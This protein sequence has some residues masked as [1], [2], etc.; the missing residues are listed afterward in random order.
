[1]R[2]KRTGVPWA[3]RYLS[4]EGGSLSIREREDANDTP[5]VV[6]SLAGSIVRPLASEVNGFVLVVKGEAPTQISCSSEQEKAAW[7]KAIKSAAASASAKSP[8]PLSRRPPPGSSP[9]PKMKEPLRE[10]IQRQ[11]AESVGKL[12]NSGA[13]PDAVLSDGSPPLCAAVAQ[14]RNGLDIAVILLDAG[15]NVRGRDV[16]GATALMKAARLG[17]ADM[18]EMLLEHAG[19]DGQSLVSEVI[20]LLDHKHQSALS[21]CSKHGHAACAELLLDHGASVDL[22]VAD[23]N[24]ALL[25]AATEG[26]D[27]IVRMLLNAGASTKVTDVE[28]ETALMKAAAEGHDPVVHALLDHDPGLIR[29]HNREHF[30]ALHY[31]ASVGHKSVVNALLG[32]GADPRAADTE[33]RTALVLAA[34]FGHAAVAT[35]LLGSLGGADMKTPVTKEEERLGLAAAQHEGH[36]DVV[37]VLEKAIEDRR[38]RDGPGLAAELQKA[39]PEAAAETL[40]A[41]EHLSKKLE[42]SVGAMASATDAMESRVSHLEVLLDKVEKTSGVQKRSDQSERAAIR[43]SVQT[44]EERVDRLEKLVDEQS[45]KGL[46]ARLAR[47]EQKLSDLTVRLTVSHKRGGGMHEDELAEKFEWLRAQQEQMLLVMSEAIQQQVLKP[48]PKD[49]RAATTQRQRKARQMQKVMP[50]AVQRKK[51]AAAATAI[52]SVHRGRKARAQQKRDRAAA[53]AI[54]KHYRTY[55]QRE[56]FQNRLTVEEDWA[57]RQIQGAWRTRQQRLFFANRESVERGYAAAAIQKTVRGK[58][59]AKANAKATVGGRR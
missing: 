32:N 31:A 52:Q 58:G 9:R 38:A 14:A 13:S 51:E 1:M 50:P 2:V 53:A 47:V 26:H 17:N 49:V 8:A 28:E 41:H 24:T 40:Q 16:H 59:K 33:G 3:R 46:E 10:A 37:R 54:Q 55:R 36:D 35:L 22:V 18:V 42:A 25:L 45:E 6:A 5:A 29:H 44:L 34:M 20:D 39:M 30:T 12:L 4:L 27:R 21:L 43:T 7:I 48:Q 57:V 56:F 11:D 23:G 15:A 19:Q